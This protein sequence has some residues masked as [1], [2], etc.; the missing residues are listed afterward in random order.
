MAG[1]ATRAAWLLSSHRPRLR[2]PSPAGRHVAQSLPRD[3]RQP[4]QAD[5]RPAQRPHQPQRG[6]SCAA[7]QS[8]PC[9]V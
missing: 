8:D 2:A 6:R 5:E 7:P 3:C 1:G 4:R 9:G